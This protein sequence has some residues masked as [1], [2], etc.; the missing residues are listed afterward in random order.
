M[1]KN[2]TSSPVENSLTCH[3]SLRKSWASALVGIAIEEGYIGSVDDPITEYIPELKGPRMGKITIRDLL[4]M[5]S[6]L[7]YSGEGS[8]GGPSGTTLRPTTTRT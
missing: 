6:G 8:G 5:S 3:L 4:T 1:N 7:K 2:E